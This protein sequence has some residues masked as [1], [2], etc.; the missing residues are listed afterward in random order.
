VTT[1]RFLAV[2]PFADAGTTLLLSLALRT[3]CQAAEFVRSGFLEVAFLAL[4]LLPGFRQVGHHGHAG[5]DDTQEATQ[6]MT[7][8]WH[9]AQ[10][11]HQVI[12]TMQIHA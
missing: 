6:E 11:T 2:V 3:D 12:E 10:F 5:T 4:A 1:T 7:A 8:G 9:A